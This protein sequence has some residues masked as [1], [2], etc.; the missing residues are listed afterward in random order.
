MITCYLNIRARREGQKYT[1]V[2]G[3]VTEEVIGNFLLKNE[4]FLVQ[5]AGNLA[6]ESSSLE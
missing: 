2:F 4:L 1:E 6:L 3:I 5:L